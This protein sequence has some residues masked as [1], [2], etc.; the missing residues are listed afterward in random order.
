MRFIDDTLC[1]LECMKTPTYL[2]RNRFGTLYFRVAIPRKFQRL[3]DDIPKEIRVSL[4]THLMR[5]AAAKA[6]TLWIYFQEA[7]EEMSD[8]KAED[9]GE[10]CAK[11]FAENK[12]KALLAK[13]ERQEKN[14]QALLEELQKL[15]PNATLDENGEVKLSDNLAASN[16]QKEQAKT[17]SDLVDKFIKERDRVGGWREKTREETIA[18]FTL[19][20][21][22]IGDL[23]LSQL[24][25]EIVRDY[26][27]T[28]Q[29]VPAN[30]N[31][32]QRFRDK[33]ITEIVCMEN[34]EPMEIRT[35]GKNL[36]KVRT[37]LKWGYDQ[38]LVSEDFAPL[39]R[40]RIVSDEDDKRHPFTASDIESLFLNDEMLGVS[41]N[42]LNKSYQF[43]V[44]LLALFT[45]ARINELCQLYVEDVQRQGKHWCISINKEKDKT[46]KNNS[47]KRLIPLSKTIIDIGFLKFVEQRKKDKS[48]RLFPELRKARDGFSSVA[49]K[50]F[51][52]YKKR[53]GIND[54]KKVFHSFRN[55]VISHLQEKGFPEA[56]IGGLVGHKSESVTFGTYANGYSPDALSELANAIDYGIDL[57]PLKQAAIRFHP[58]FR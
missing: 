13:K 14:K 50:W 27:E 15:N 33:S 36:E 37:L 47:S 10:I 42:S 58:D 6:R 25:H 46:L 31:K 34:V 12:A 43:W 11:L 32:I 17:I 44:P 23:P 54:P 19:F 53:F 3:S 29:K 2:V 22:I 24:T 9:A 55:T 49:S 48:E 18:K 38:R 57:S 1:R 5:D 56:K 52:L 30:V 16:K 41:S 21:R 7:F 51:A 4:R 39:L 20:K 26:K 40:L 45:G 35:L 28:I 8:I